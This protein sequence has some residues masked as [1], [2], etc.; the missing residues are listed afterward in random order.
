[1]IGAMRS[2]WG[3]KLIGGVIAVIAFVF[4]FYGIFVPGSG[5]TGP[6]VAGEINGEPIT[7]SEF[8]KAR[9]QQIEYM[10]GMLGGKIS[11]AQ[12]EQFHI[13]EN[14]FKDLAQRKVLAQ[15]AKKEGFYP[16]AEQIREQIV[17]MDVFQKDGR[18]DK[19]LYKNVLAANQLNPV[20][21]EDLMGQEIMNQNFRNFLGQL[22]PLSP[23]EVE[24]ELRSTR[25]RHKYR[26]VYLDN[27]SVRKMLPSDLKEVEKGA[28]LDEK[29]KELEQKVLP[30]LSSGNDAG[31]VSLLAPAKIKV[32]TSDWITAQSNIIPGVGSVRSIQDGLFSMRK[33]APAQSFSLMGGTFLA[34]ALETDSADLSKVSAKDRMAAANKVQSEKQNDLLRRFIADLMK[35]AKI[36]RNDS[37]ISGGKAES[38][39]LTLDD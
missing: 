15:K 30:L 22:A 36:V 18:F 1:M 7:Y 39:P 28:K 12:L 19:V 37:L 32:K 38:L 21:F 10:K 4:I 24:Q 8:S 20:R 27:E 29:V 17:K 26:Y 23:D 5:S 31:I 34:V 13:G 2:K 3:P 35:N 14:V 6:G 9:S 16:S 25:D 11:E 33:G